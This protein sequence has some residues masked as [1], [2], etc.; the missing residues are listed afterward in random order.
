MSPLF[1]FRRFLT[2]IAMVCAV[3]IQVLGQEPDPPPAGN[4]IAAEL[5]PHA[6]WRFGDFGK[7]SGR[8]GSRG[9]YVMTFSPNGKLMA[10]RDGNN[11]FRLFD[12]E[13]QELLFEFKSYED[14]GYI[15]S[16]DFSPDSSLLLVGSEG[17]RDRVTVWN[18]KTGELHSTL[19]TDAKLAYFSSN[20]EI[21]VLKQRKVYFYDVGSGKSARS[22]AWGSSGD[23]PHSFSRSGQVV[24]AQRRSQKNAYK[25]Q[26]VD[27]TKET[28]T[29]LLNC[30]TS[31]LRASAFS[32]NGNWVVAKFEREKVA[33][34]WDLRDPHKKGE[35]KLVAHS[36]T[37]YSACFSPDNRFLATTGWDK[38]V[39]LWDV[40]SGERIG[41][42]SGHEDHVN[43]CSFSPYDFVLATGANGMSDNSLILW[44]FEDLVFPEVD[45]P[46]EYRFD[47]LWN[48]LSSSEHR[49]ALNAVAYL[50]AHPEKFHQ[51]ISDQ[52]GVAAA[53]AS[54]EQIHDWIEQLSSRRFAQR[55]KAEELLKKARMRAEQI[56][57][58]TL[59][60]DDIVLEV[61][62]RIQRILNQPVERPKIPPPELHRLHRT[63]YALELIGT[64]RSMDVL[65]NI[66][67]AHS[68][69]DIARDAANSVNR[70]KARS[71][72]S[73]TENR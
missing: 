66:A 6:L 8:R 52:L 41:K 44:D 36:D 70:I 12:V 32:P 7:G 49:V 39:Y 11:L 62:Y 20:S 27:L 31:I 63:I 28:T 29:I 68:H 61:K 38:V 65:Q 45:A 14:L 42:L 16:M 73:Q 40:L 17:V 18:T 55:T 72:Q 2:L 34:L 43:I 64:P 71:S 15:K 3:T 10:A 23:I 1:E 58:A 47:E 51:E 25:T 60:R 37:I 5:P 26:V 56:L 30:P 9:Y 67:D 69:I 59:E 54:V 57:K 19:E 50:R 24:L 22:S 53:G 46:K 35:N 48:A 33:Y 4:E 13:S 21:V